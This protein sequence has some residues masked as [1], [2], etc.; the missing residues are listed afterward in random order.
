MNY[1]AKY[2]RET[3][4]EWKRKKDSIVARYIH[5]PISFYFSSFFTKIGLTSNQ[6]SFLSF[7]ISIITCLLFL[8][9][10]YWMS[11]IAALLVNL[12]SITDS[13]DGNMARSLGGKPY[14][15]F[16]DAISSYF[17]V[18]FMF[19]CISWGIYK[20]GGQLISSGCAEIILI[21]GLTG[22]FDTMSRLFF[23]KMNSNTYEIEM[24]DKSKNNNC[25][26]KSMH[27]GKLRKIYSRIESELGLGGW[28][29]LAIV[30]CS[31][32]NSLDLYVLFYFIFYG[33]I[34]I[35]STIYMILTT[36]CLTN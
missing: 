18:G 33:S 22:L 35:F 5:R 7:I 28:N 4:P 31:I 15:D 30:I 1:S 9:T 12:W 34:F 26:N 2:F 32:N 36:K 23:Q 8:F 19:P 14:G 21:G 6:V 17:L 10:N 16:I 24:N 25:N 29:M 20:N 3:M 27:H 11:I 13:A